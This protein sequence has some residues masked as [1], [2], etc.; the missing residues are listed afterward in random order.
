MH[1]HKHTH[2]HKY[3][4]YTL[5]PH[6]HQIKVKLTCICIWIQIHISIHIWIWMYV[7]DLK[8]LSS[9]EQHE[10]KFPLLWSLNRSASPEPWLR[11][12]SAYSLLWWSAVAFNTQ[13]GEETENSV[14]WRRT[15]ETREVSSSEDKMLRTQMFKAVFKAASRPRG[16]PE[17]ENIPCHRCP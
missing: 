1:I 16:L 15:E 5:P 2:S 3:A 8:N 17:K 12:V 13:E 9:I 4:P 11:W 7:W 10:I 14:L 6:T